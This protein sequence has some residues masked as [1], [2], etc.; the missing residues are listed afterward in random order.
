MKQEQQKHAFLIGVYQNPDYASS[1]VESLRGDR[2]NIY[3]H[4]NPLYMSDFRGFLEK[5]ANE[6]DVKVISSQPVKWG[7]KFFIMVYHR[8][9][10]PSFAR[11]RDWMVPHAY[12]T[13]YLD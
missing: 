10:E 5:Y 3:V 11:C 6:S 8:I 4:I 7:G 13:R 2:S 1:L 9:A 12:R